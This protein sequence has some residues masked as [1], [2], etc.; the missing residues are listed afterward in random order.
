MGISHL[1]LTY[2]VCARLLVNMPAV[3]TEEAA[4]RASISS[5]VLAGLFWVF[6]SSWKKISW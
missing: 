3:V 1:Q 4:Q 6:V 5:L 2:C